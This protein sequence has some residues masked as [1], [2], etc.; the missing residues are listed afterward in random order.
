MDIRHKSFKLKQK[1]KAVYSWLQYELALLCE[2]KGLQNSASGP[3]CVCMGHSSVNFQI[4][5][6]KKEA[7]SELRK[8]WCPPQ[9]FR[10]LAFPTAWKELMVFPWTLL[11]F[12]IENA[13]EGVR[14]EP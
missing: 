3:L 5:L 8:A 6:T 9:V 2:R 11:N 10:K 13:T 14:H 7:P 1:P 12:S 4:C